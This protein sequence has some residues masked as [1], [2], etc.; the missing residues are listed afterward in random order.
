M[1]LRQHVKDMHPRLKNRRALADLERDHAKDHHHYRSGH[2]HNDPDV[3]PFGQP[4]RMGM[5]D[6]HTRPRGWKTGEDVEVASRR[7]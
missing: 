2:V 1:S 4:P 7:G 5:P 6:E 3:G